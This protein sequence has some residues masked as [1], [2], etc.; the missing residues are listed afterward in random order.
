M[1]SKG[2]APSITFNADERKAERA[3]QVITIGGKEFH[4]RPRTV[5]LMDNLAEIAPEVFGKPLDREKNPTREM[6]LINIQ[7]DALLV[8]GD[9]AGP[10]V[11]FLND[12]L[13]LDDG[14]DLL[15]MLAPSKQA[16]DEAVQD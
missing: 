7:L 15:E 6:H 3:K 14:M 16:R 8:D 13:D 9:D 5:A 4:P 2:H 10:G 11:E 1:A 12:Q